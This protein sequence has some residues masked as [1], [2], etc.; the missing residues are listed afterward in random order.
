MGEDCEQWTEAEW[1]AW[2]ATTPSEHHVMQIAAAWSVD[3]SSLDD[4]QI[5]GDGIHGHPAAHEHS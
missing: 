4:D 3:P 2:F 5:S 1:D